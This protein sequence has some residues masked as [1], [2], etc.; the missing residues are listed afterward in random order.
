MV[1]KLVFRVT[2]FFCITVFVGHFLFT[3]LDVIPFNPVSAKHNTQVYQYMEPVFNQTW[4]LF[5]PD[6]VA[7]NR[8]I[9]MQIKKANGEKSDWYDITSPMIEQNHSNLISPHNR[10]VRIP[11]SSV[12]S[13]FQEDATSSLIKDNLT[14][15]EEDHLILEEN[16]E[17]HLDL[18]QERAKHKMYRYAFSEAGRLHEENNIAEVQLRLEITEVVPFSERNNEDYESESHYIELPWKAY[19]Q[20]AS[21]Y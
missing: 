14:D 1:K 3:L 19:T 6:P 7:D 9:Y 16:L 4:E 13:L 12:I 5:A 2:S 21:P 20:V 17:N 8:I 11:T 15:D 18:H 10:L